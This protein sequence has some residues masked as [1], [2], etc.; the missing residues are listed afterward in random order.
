MSLAIRMIG[1]TLSIQIITSFLFA[2]T[3]S[4]SPPSGFT[5]DLFQ[6]RINSSSSLIYNT[7]LGSSP[8][9]DTLFDTFEYLM[10]LQ[11]GTPP[12]EIE[13]IFF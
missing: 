9:A 11:I 4:S 2:A 8:Y 6:R 5:I 1:L 3:V 7:Q 12:V 10:K 13:A